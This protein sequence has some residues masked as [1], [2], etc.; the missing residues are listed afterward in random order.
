[1]QSNV[2]KVATLAAG[3]N[4]ECSLL[5]VTVLPLTHLEACA[6]L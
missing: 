5:L 4:L 6:G 3:R 1:M 2:P